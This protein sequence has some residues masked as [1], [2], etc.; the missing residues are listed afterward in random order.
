[1]NGH[2]I[3]SR[4]NDNVFNPLDTVGLEQVLRDKVNEMM[5]LDMW[6]GSDTPVELQDDMLEFMQHELEQ[7]VFNFLKS[8]QVK[9]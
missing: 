9:S 3:Y 2:F 1:M 4:E 6:V 7:T 5:L 8:K